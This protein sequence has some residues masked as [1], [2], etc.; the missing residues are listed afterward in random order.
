MR[1]PLFRPVFALLTI[2]P[3]LD[4]LSL[5]FFPP[6]WALYPPCSLLR[7][8]DSTPSFPP[9]QILKDNLPFL[10]QSPDFAYQTGPIEVLTAIK[11]ASNLNL[12]EIEVLPH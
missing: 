3:D 4:H 2:P 10:P 6:L 12:K 5:I 8:C 9:K 1:R 7:P 11:T